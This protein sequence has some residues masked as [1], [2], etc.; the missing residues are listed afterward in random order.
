MPKL[1]WAKLTK[2]LD[3]RLKCPTRLILFPETGNVG[4]NLTW[5]QPLPNGWPET[6]G[7]AQVRGNLSQ[8]NEIYTCSE[9]PEGSQ[10]N[11][12]FCFIP[13]FATT[14]TKTAHCR[15]NS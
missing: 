14:R 5:L 15:G 9:C 7:A 4:V 8:K 11:P 1:C 6:K 2:I 10:M 3:A 13:M 12:G